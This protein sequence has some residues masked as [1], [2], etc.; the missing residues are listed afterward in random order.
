MA[1]SALFIAVQL[2]LK[3]PLQNKSVTFSILLGAPRLIPGTHSFI[4][5]G[6]G[7]KVADGYYILARDPT[8][9][10][11]VQWFD[12]ADGAASSVLEPCHQRRLLAIA[13]FGASRAEICIFHLPIIKLWL[14]PLYTCPTSIGCAKLQDSGEFR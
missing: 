5:H 10:A 7:T 8:L 11:T 13:F 1:Y 4:F 3:L 12:R 14:S 2:V 9:K 6:N